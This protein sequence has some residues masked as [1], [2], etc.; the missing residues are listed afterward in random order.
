AVAIIVAT[1]TATLAPQGLIALAPLLTGARA[2]AQ[3][4][5]RRRATDGLLAPLAVL[6]AALSLITVVVFRDQTLAT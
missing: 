1:L 4:I 6:A 2:I 5:R 3:R